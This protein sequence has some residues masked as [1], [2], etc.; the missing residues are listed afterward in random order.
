MHEQV[1]PSLLSSLRVPVT[2]EQFE[3]LKA[4]D[5]Y[6]LW[7]ITERLNKNS[8]PAH[9]VSQA[10][11]EFKKYI[12]LFGLGYETIGMI[13]EE[14]DEVWHNFILFTKEYAKFCQECFGK[15][16]HHAPNTSQHPQLSIDSVMNFVNAYT[17]VFGEL[18]AIWRTPEFEHMLKNDFMVRGEC[19][20]PINCSS[21]T[22]APDTAVGY[23]PVGDCHMGGPAPGLAALATAVGYT[24]IGDCA[25]GGPA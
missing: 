15:F 25:D 2:N 22:S 18:P 10:A 23:T 21:L 11:I 7:F 14:V 12:A 4:I 1:K 16:V 5:E 17:K 9:L 13:S 19:E 3:I 6:D 20:G 24:S 8:I